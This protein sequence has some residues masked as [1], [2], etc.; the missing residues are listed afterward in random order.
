MTNDVKHSFLCLFGICIFS[1]FRFLPTFNWIFEF[2]LLNFIIIVVIFRTLCIFVN[3]TFIK[4]PFY[5][6]F[7]P[8]WGLPFHSLND[9]FPWIEVFNPDYQFFLMDL[10]FGVVCKNPSPNSNSHIL[11]ST[12]SSKSF[13]VLCF[14]YVLCS[15]LS[16]FLFKVEVC[17]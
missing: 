17:V 10:D 7:L 8:F 5:K 4:Y 16:Y 1:L 15:I 3:K 12:F 14:T 6:H 13:I 2:S 9:V 11:S